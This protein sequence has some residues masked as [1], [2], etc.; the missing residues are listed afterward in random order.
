MEQTEQVQLT[1]EESG[2]ICHALMAK[3]LESARNNK[4]RVSFLDD[5]RLASAV[6]QRYLRLYAKIAAA[7]DKLMGKR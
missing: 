2:W 4:G 5:P 1:L 7:N 6:E 3:M